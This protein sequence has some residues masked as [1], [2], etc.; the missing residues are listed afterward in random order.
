MSVSHKI[1]FHEKICEKCGPY[2]RD[3]SLDDKSGLL[4]NRG[5]PQT[6]CADCA[7]MFRRSSSA[8]ATSRADHRSPR[9]VRAGQHRQLDRGRWEAVP[10]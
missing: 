8:V 2:L 6:T 1:G 9:S 4:G 7:R 10:R 5:L 3:Q